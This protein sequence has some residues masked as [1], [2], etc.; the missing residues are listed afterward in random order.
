MMEYILQSPL[1]RIVKQLYDTDQEFKE[2]KRSQVLLLFVCHSYLLSLQS[3]TS[4]GTDLNGNI[5][6]DI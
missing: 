3:L 6:I 2:Y 1:Q 4:L 5:E